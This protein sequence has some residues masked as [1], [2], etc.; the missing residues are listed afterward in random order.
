[1]VLGLGQQY[2]DPRYSAQQAMN[3][4]RREFGLGR[5]AEDDPNVQRAQQFSDIKTEA[6]PVIEG[7]KVQ[8]DMRAATTF[9]Q[10]KQAGLSGLAEQFRRSQKAIAFDTARRGTLGGSRSIER[11]G[12]AQNQAQIGAGDVLNQA[13]GAANNQRSQGLANIFG[14]ES[15]LA[16]NDPFQAISAQNQLGAMQQQG[17]AAMGQFDLSQQRQDVRQGTSMNNANALFGGLSSLGTGLGGI[18]SNN[19]DINFINKLK[20]LGGGT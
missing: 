20:K 14:F 7:A 15:S 8:N 5:L 12:E 2:E 17:Q 19:A 6:Q 11:V 1:M 18:V 3:L 9:N 16:Q 10:I 4:Q 13:Q